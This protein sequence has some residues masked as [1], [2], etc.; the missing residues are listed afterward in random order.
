MLA[1]AGGNLNL[2]NHQR[3][4]IGFETATG[5]KAPASLRRFYYAHGLGLMWSRHDAWFEAAPADLKTLVQ[6]KELPLT[7]GVS[8]LSVLND[9]RL[10]SRSSLPSKVPSSDFSVCYVNLW[11][12]VNFSTESYLFTTPEHDR[13]VWI[14][15]HDR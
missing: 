7:N 15:R 14:Y 11:Q 5:A 2:L 4:S 12:E 3:F 8:L 13:A 10:I 1:L 6:A 9:D